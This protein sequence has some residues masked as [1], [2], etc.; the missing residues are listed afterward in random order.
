[1]E[2]VSSTITDWVT[3]RW[4]TT[5]VHRYKLKERMEYLEEEAC[6]I[7]E[8][9]GQ[10]AS[11]EE[12]RIAYRKHFCDICYANKEFAYSDLCLG[13][14]GEEIEWTIPPWTNE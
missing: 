6:H 8:E 14:Q 2:T 9:E 12:W 5:E 11:F 7:L 1:M 10:P 13:S 4:A 3:A